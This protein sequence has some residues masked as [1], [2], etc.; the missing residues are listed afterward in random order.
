MDK[1]EMLD[2]FENS[3]VIKDLHFAYTTDRKALDNIN[4][5]FEKNKKY[6]IV[7]ESGCGKSTLIKLLMR[8]YKD[9][10]GS[11][12]IDNKH[13]HNYG[14]SYHWSE[15]NLTVTAIR[16]CTEC[17]EETIKSVRANVAIVQMQDCTHEELTTYTATF[18][19]KDFK[20]QIKENIVRRIKR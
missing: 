20:T 18:K 16:K 4:L 17:D 7:G 6:A 10:D 8:Y 19:D 2:K 9:Y 3:I 12:L 14:I 15:D 11:I 5:T 13:I 1:N